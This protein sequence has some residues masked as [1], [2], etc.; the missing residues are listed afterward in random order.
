MG[1]CFLVT[2]GRPAESARARRDTDDGRGTGRGMDNN[3]NNSLAVNL[4]TTSSRR[5]TH[6]AT[7]LPPEQ[8]PRARRRERSLRGGHITPTHR[9]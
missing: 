8:H 2:D 3:K 1:S 5:P 4:S 6:T 9:R 7:G